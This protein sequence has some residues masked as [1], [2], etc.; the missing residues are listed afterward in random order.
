MANGPHAAAAAAESPNR[1]TRS[2]AATV[3]GTNMGEAD[4]YK[5]KRRGSTFVDENMHALRG[6][7]A[8]VHSERA[9]GAAAVAAAIKA[10]PKAQGRLMAEAAA[11]LAAPRLQEK[12]EIANAIAAAAPVASAV[13]AAIKGREVAALAAAAA[14]DHREDHM[15]AAEVLNARRVEHAIVESGW[16]A[17][18]ASTNLVQNKLEEL[19]MN[20][21]NRLSDLLA[22]LQTCERIITDRTLTEN[23][24]GEPAMR[25]IITVM[26][27]L[28]R[29]EM[30]TIM[31]G[32]SPPSLLSGSLITVTVNSE[33]DFE[34]RFQFTRSLQQPPRY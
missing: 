28:E 26:C 13:A 10:T 1:G 15:T 20:D 16:K 21:W 33:V 23:Q 7:K 27:R 3:S 24:I 9:Q 31:A 2:R 8:M 5:A 4:V 11:A 12:Q 6:A 34:N 17:L 32:L 29:A 30:L 25:E 19:S 18:T 14:A 22:R